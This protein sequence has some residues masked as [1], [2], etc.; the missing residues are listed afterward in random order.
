[1]SGVCCPQI[2]SIFLKHRAEVID[3]DDEL[4]V[5]AVEVDRVSVFEDLFDK[6]LKFFEAKKSLIDAYMV[7]YENATNPGDMKDLSQIVGC[8]D[9]FPLVCLI[10]CMESHVALAHGGVP[11]S[12]LSSTIA[13]LSFR[14]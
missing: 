7:A 5:E 6:E 12:C 10:C 1:M 4:R 11:H 13:C 9:N 3:L 2:G 8:A 14:W